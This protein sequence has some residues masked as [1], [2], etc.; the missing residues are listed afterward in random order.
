M[1]SFHLK[2]NQN[3]QRLPLVINEDIFFTTS[4]ERNVDI[5][6][7]FRS[8]TDKGQWIL[9]EVLDRLVA[10]ERSVVVLCASDYF[11]LK[12]R[13]GS[14]VE[15]IDLPLDQYSLA[16]IFRKI[17]VF[18]DTSLHEGFGLMPLEA[19]L[20]GCRLVVSDSGGVRGF[21]SHF[22]GE[23]IAGS[24]DPTAFLNA[25][26]RQL[27]KFNHE[28]PLRSLPF[29]MKESRNAWVSYVEDKTLNTEC[30]AFLHS[31]DV[32]AIAIIT[33]NITSAY[34]RNLLHY[35]AIEAYRLILPYVPRR[36]HLAFKVLV[37]GKI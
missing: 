24:S 31:P 7:V 20:C 19:A 35:L 18:I 2:Q 33:K 28:A 15:F 1:V 27:K 22:D 32:G 9:A 17:K 29:G 3:I 4:I 16:K 12:N 36:I 5:C 37:Y 8:S 30:G 34:R 6:M 13:F 25:I 21:V 23:L 14:K 26:D 11:F 10:S